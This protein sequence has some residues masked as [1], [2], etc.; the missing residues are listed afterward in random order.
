MNLGE[1]FDQ[2]R[3]GDRK[4]S[5]VVG[6]NNYPNRDYE[7]AAIEYPTEYNNSKPVQ[8]P[9]KNSHNPPESSVTLVLS[10]HRPASLKRVTPSTNKNNNNTTNVSPTTGHHNTPMQPSDV[11]RSF[12]GSIS[13]TSSTS[14]G[15]S[16]TKKRSFYDQNNDDR[17][18]GSTTV[19][20]TH[21]KASV[22]TPSTT[23]TKP[24]TPV[25]STGS[26]RIRENNT[27][28][29]ITG[30]TSESVKDSASSASKPLVSPRDKSIDPKLLPKISP[31][32]I[33][34][35]NNTG[36]LGSAAFLDRSPS[37]PQTSYPIGSSSSSSNIHGVPKTFVSSRIPSDNSLPSSH[38][39]VSNIY[40]VISQNTLCSMCECTVVD[41]VVANCGNLFCRRCFESAIKSQ[42]TA[43]LLR[44]TR[45]DAS[46]NI[47][48]S[49]QFSSSDCVLCP[50]TNCETILADSLFLNSMVT[51]I[52]EQ[53]HANTTPP[54][55]IN[56]L[57]NAVITYTLRN[58]CI[59]LPWLDN[60]VTG[61]G[62]PHIIHT[63]KAY[64]SSN[65]TMSSFGRLITNYHQSHQNQSSHTTEHE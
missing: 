42:L 2:V 6:G 7:V 43:L 41:A 1:Q 58:L 46:S 24:G 36:G 3:D 23:A 22:H 57:K 27:G 12:S 47:T 19:T 15:S 29:K 26:K 17:M 34:K 54:I 63:D 21:T 45:R 37:G 18:I 16:S 56:V 11:A 32:T 59:R 40:A 4:S 51:M 44:N 60:I 62:M 28:E 39:N 49:L 52:M 25:V 55:T 64:D 13:Q 48:S 35:T 50:V 65:T 31:S 9:T 14:L 10:G 8:T 33:S 38:G 5:V 53:L 61:T 20:A 30:K